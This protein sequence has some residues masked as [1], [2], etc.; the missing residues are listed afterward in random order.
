MEKAAGVIKGI[1]IAM[2]MRLGTGKLLIYSLL[3]FL[4]VSDGKLVK[5]EISLTIY[6]LLENLS[7]KEIID[8]FIAHVK[9]NY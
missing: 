9:L 3:A 8:R 7:N 1:A 4:S 2:A 6:S 5:D